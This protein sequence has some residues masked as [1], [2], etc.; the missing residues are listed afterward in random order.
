[1]KSALSWRVGAAAAAGVLSVT[2]AACGSSSGGSS[3]GSGG[4]YTLGVMINDTTNPFLST[5]GT[6]LTKAASKYGMKVDLLNGNA[7]NSTQLSDVQ[8][9]INKHVNAILL[10]PSDPVAILPAVKEANQA[11]IPVFALNSAIAKGGKLVTY[12]GDSDYQY[13]IAEGNLAVKAI[14][15]RGNVAVLLGVL[16]DSPE[17]QRL[18]GIKAVLAKY[19]HIKIVTTEV[20]N[21]QNS[22]NLADTQDLLS[23]YGK[24]TLQAVIAQGPEMYVGAGYAAKA[25]RTD[26]KFIAGDYSTQVE[27][28]IKAGQLY[29]TVDQSPVLEGQLG[30]KAAYDWLKGDKSAVK[31]P[32]DYISLPVVTAAN[33]AK[34][35]AEWSG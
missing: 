27:S 17:V 10:T 15:G 21:W 32:N 18:A 22:K 33:V 13:G 6:A 5:M 4:H 28:A 25:G 14:H 23:K 8:D 19:P 16:G 31:A 12:I 26:V 9:L 2:L 3:G 11:G 7:D 35:P 30:A 29:G 24:G 20:D 34:Y 1:M